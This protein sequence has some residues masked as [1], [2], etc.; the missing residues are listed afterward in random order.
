VNRSTF[1]SDNLD[2]AVVI[3]PISKSL[4]VQAAHAASGVSYLLIYLSELNN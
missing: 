1:A 3:S 4:H 2:R